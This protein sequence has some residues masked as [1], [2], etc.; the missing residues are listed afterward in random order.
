M[1][2]NDAFN[3]LVSLTSLLSTI[4]DNAALISAAIGNAQKEGRDTL[5]ADEWASINS[6][7]DVARKALVDALATAV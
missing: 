4:A 7:D 1:N 6:L 3:K 2:V 5:T